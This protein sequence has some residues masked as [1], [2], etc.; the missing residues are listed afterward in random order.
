MTSRKKGPQKPWR[1]KAAPKIKPLDPDVPLAPYR[2]PAPPRGK[3]EHV[4]GQQMIDF[5]SD[6]PDALI[7]PE[8]EGA[9]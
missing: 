8:A 9:A 7:D 3:F 4:P 6:D 1:L 2:V 5:S